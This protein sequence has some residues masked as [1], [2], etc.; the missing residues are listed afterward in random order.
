M[1]VKGFSIK[2]E[3]TFHGQVYG[4]SL[5][6]AQGSFKGKDNISHKNRRGP[7]CELVIISRTSLAFP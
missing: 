5:P 4:S 3:G 7:C 6:L 2:F 1:D